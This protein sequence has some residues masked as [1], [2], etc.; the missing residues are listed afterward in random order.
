MKRVGIL[1]SDFGPYHVARIEALGR[2]LAGQGIE[3]VAFR[4]T[5]R[6]DTYGWEPV[7][8]QGMETVTLADRYPSGAG[9]AARLA[10]RFGQELHQRRVG[11][12]FLPTYSP[13]PNLLCLLAA[14]AAGCKTVLMTESWLGTEKT[15]RL[16]RLAKH[17]LVR[18]FDSALVGGTPQRDFVVAYGMPPEKVFTGYDVV[19]N[20]FF[21]RQA[22]AV[23]SAQKG[24]QEPESE[25]IAS[26][27][28]VDSVQP[29]GTAEQIL[30]EE[31]R[32][33]AKKRLQ[34]SGHGGQA[35]GD[36]RQEPE[37]G[38]SAPSGLRIQ[39]SDLAS[40][41]TA[42]GLPERF[43]LNL[44][45]FVE[46]KNLS[47]LVAA[48][49][50][51]VQQAVA[52]SPHASDL[53]PQASIPAL[54]LVGEGPL[55]GEL[56]C[57]AQELGLNVVDCGENPA[58]PLRGRG[59]TVRDDQSGC[60]GRHPSSG[61]V[62]HEENRGAVF[63]YGFQQSDMT[64]VFFALCEAFILP[65]LYEEWGLVVNEAM[66]C[67]APVIV[68]RNVGS[69]RDLVADAVGTSGPLVRGSQS[70]HAGRV[71]PPP[72][73]NGFTFDPEDVDGLAAILA[74]F[75]AD[76]QLRERLGKA[77]REMIREWGPDKFGEQGLMALKAAEG[78]GV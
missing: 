20:E 11:A 5:E 73:P 33:Q 62:R 67:G 10:W 58:G 18:M 38:S 56:E 26:G 72:E 8:P 37:A 63:F 15:G 40:A 28:S 35:T 24:R 14:K 6:S 74:R 65:S 13:L 59:L 78:G 48:Y 46:K 52:S 22:D 9:A 25:E 27:Q 2:S 44:G 54:V 32:K 69:A 36:R 71:S 19:E 4:F 68:S 41:I 64:P 1:F 57:Q 51:Y 29:E 45:R 23:R 53:A 39:Q 70:G 42:L 77:G 75:D 61:E 47:T 50:R 16:G 49:S 31:V 30:A 21:A 3:L 66:A 12:V 17:V 43:F 55:R 34:S 7:L 60:R 76:P